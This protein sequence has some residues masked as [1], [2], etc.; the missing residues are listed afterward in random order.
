MLSLKQTCVLHEQIG[1]LYFTESLCGCWKQSPFARHT[2]LTELFWIQN[3][4]AENPSLAL[5]R[6][7]VEKLDRFGVVL[8]EC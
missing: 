5:S 2:N 6:A 7:C 4:A 3:S 1:N 8:V